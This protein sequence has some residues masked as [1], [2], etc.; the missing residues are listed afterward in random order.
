MSI[1]NDVGVDPTTDLEMHHVFTR[2]AVLAAW[3]AT[4]GHQ[5]HVL[6]ERFAAALGTQQKAFALAVDSLVPHGLV[7]QP[8]GFFAAGLFLLTF[9]GGPCF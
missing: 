7:L 2:K 1:R 5:V 9:E 6:A 8:L 3:I 4:V